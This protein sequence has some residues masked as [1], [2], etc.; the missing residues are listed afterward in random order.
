[1]KSYYKILIVCLS[2]LFFVGCK[3]H[4]PAV[5]D[6]PTEAVDFTYLVSDATYQLDYYVGATIKFYPTV[7]LNTPCIWDFGDG[8]FDVPVAY[9]VQVEMELPPLVFAEVSCFRGGI[10]VAEVEML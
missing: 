3:E 1:M 4:V 2:V 6:L 5:E 7:N 10:A 9:A 8:S